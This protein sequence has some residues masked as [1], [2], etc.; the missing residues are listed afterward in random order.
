MLRSRSSSDLQQ[1]RGSTG[2]SGEAESPLLVPR[3]ERRG[4]EK[5]EV[6]FC[7]PDGPVQVPRQSLPHVGGE[8]TKVGGHPTCVCCS[9]MWVCLLAQVPDL[10]VNGAMENRSQDVG[11][12]GGRGEDRGEGEGEE[13]KREEGGERGG[14]G[15]SRDSQDE[16]NEFYTLLDTTLH[17]PESPSVRE[18]RE[19]PLP[20]VAFCESEGEGPHSDNTTTPLPSGRLKD[21]VVALRQ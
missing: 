4:R 3:G 8:P 18:E 15:G 11:E 13:G 16:I 5:E 7:E 12:G 19:A 20:R 1:R 2:S 10:R 6:D 9:L 21:R 14:G 17:L